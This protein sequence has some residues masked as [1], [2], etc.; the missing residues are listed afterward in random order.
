MKQY[1]M[2]LIVMIFL[3]FSVTVSWAGLNDGLITYYPLDETKGETAHDASG[4][5]RDAVFVGDGM[6][7]DESG[8]IGGALYFDGDGG[9]LL[10]D[11]ASDYLNGLS[12]Y[13]LSLWVKAE[14]VP[15]DKGLIFTKE[16][17][18]SDE[19]LGLR[20]DASG[21]AGGGTSV[22]KT[23]MS[24]TGDIAGQ[25]DKQLESSNNVQTTDWQHIAVTWSDGNQLALYIDGEKDEEPTWPSKELTGTTKDVEKLLIGKGGKDEGNSSWL[26]L[27]DDVRIYSRVLNHQEIEDLAA[28]KVAALKPAGKI[29]TTWGEIK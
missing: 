4:N 14:E 8:K 26:G 28:G 29:A 1:K 20:Y 15:T 23:S 12:A 13:T 18:G 24:P 25:K 2:I 3:A 11:D 21:W 9:A 19:W 17:D 5:S 10:D 6:T 16:P 7:W 22:I 27:I